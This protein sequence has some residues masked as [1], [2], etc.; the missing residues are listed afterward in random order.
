MFDTICI[1]GVGLIGGSFGLAAREKGL[2]RRITGVARRAETIAAAVALGAVDF[3]TADVLKAAQ[4]ADLVF[5]APPVG[6][7]KALCEQIAPVI[8]AG[9]IVT[10]AGSTKSGL[11]ADC[12]P[13]F[14]GKA[15]FVGGHP[16]AGS[17][18]TGVEA[19]R[20]DLFR[21]ATWI[22]TPTP[23]T[24]DFAVE[25]LKKVVEAVGA[26]PLLLDPDTHD[27][28]LAVTSHLPHVTATALM[29]AFMRAQSEHEIAQK[30]VAGG[31]RDATRVAAGSPE[32]WRDI[33]L[34]NAPALQKSLDELIEELGRLRA[35]LLEKDGEA[36]L[37]WFDEA[38]V[39]RRSQGYLP[40]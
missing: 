38:A 27:A 9:A 30:L 25:K 12:T 33:A 4:D 11:V 31:W 18:Q 24:P 6:Q 21:G 15:V 5:L 3:A 17:E 13:I 39:A 22:L 8:R 14:A 19:A 16:M 37:K 40:H 7:M 1:V 10:D 29:H 36:L 2:A 20:A 23:Q 35:L 28:L 26:T 32:M 34:A